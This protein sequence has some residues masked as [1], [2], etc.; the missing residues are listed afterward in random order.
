MSK[1]A[2]LFSAVLAGAVLS[3]SFSAPVE[4]QAASGYADPAVCLDC[5]QEVADQLALTQHGKSG[6]SQ[7]SDH[8]CQGCHGPAAAHA[9]DPSDESLIPSILD[10]SAEAQTEI[11][12]G[13]HKGGEQFF[14]EDG[15]HGRR[16][17]SCSTCHSVHSPVSDVAQLRA[18]SVQAQCFDCHKDIR[19]E[20]W[21]RSHH[22]VREGQISCSDCHNPHGTQAEA[23]LRTASVNETCYTCHT[24]KRG[25]FLW[26]HAPVRESCLNCHTPHGSNHFKLQKTSTP[27]LCQQCHANTRHP[28]SIYDNRTNANGPSPSSREFNRGCLNCHAAIHGSNHPSAPYLAH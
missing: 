16:D 14:W 28:S 17:L 26:E 8:G 25:P 3:L 4:A 1:Q 13:C 23:M 19:A 11:C 10:L 24:E 18:V 20:S 7:L 22:P 9:D 27:F 21:K 5:H 15:K 6:Y 2:L 12:Q